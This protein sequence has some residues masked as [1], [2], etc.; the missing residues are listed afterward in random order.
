MCVTNYETT[1]TDLEKSQIIDYILNS[2]KGSV[3]IV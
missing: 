3:A 2:V 1:A